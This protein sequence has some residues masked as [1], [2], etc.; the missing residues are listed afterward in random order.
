[1]KHSVYLTGMVMALAGCSH[2]PASNSFTLQ[3]EFDEPFTGMV[4]IRQ[5]KDM[6]VNID[7]VKLEASM[8]F[9]KK[10][11]IP[12]TDEFM[13][14]TVPY[15][16]SA[17]FIGQDGA[18]Y[19]LKFDCKERTCQLTTEQAPEQEIMEEYNRMVKPYRQ[20]NEALGRSY[21]AVRKKSDIDSMKLI[22]DQMEATFK[23]EKQQ[24]KALIKSHKESFAAVALSHLL[25]MN[26]Y[27]EYKEVYEQLDT[28]AYASTHSMKKLKRKMDEAKSLW[29]EGS[30]APLFTTRNLKGETVKLEDF[31]GKY[32]LLD[33]WASWCHSC[34]VKA[35]AIKKVYPEL[36]KRGIVML[37]VSMDEKKKAWEKASAEDQIS[38]TN[39]SELA[40]FEK[41]RIAQDYKVRQLPT[42]FLIGPDGKIVKQNPEL[43]DLLKLPVRP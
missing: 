33:F 35:K 37:G 25:F 16:G 19:R 20:K 34:R 2:G 17:N 7:S 15:K 13:V 22:S 6:A 31:R 28:A 36:Q 42:L 27:P 14:R 12:H 30:M 26:A 4:Y 9:E 43:E 5:M 39:T 41:N 38:W 24:T 32:V 40:R 23:E 11:T 18:V 1:M 10:T 8:G 29:M 3:G 21:E